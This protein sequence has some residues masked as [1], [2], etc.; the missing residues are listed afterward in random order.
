MRKLLAVLLLAALPSLL[1][2]CGQRPQPIGAESDPL[3]P[4]SI[5]ITN[6]SFIPN[7]LVVTAGQTV[8]WK[9]EDSLTPHNVTFADDSPVSPT[10][11]NGTWSHTFDTPGTYGYRCTIHRDMSAVVVVRPSS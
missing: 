4:H 6:L 3:P 1:A 5:V 2:A 9:W 7:R 11:A 10:Q 8:T